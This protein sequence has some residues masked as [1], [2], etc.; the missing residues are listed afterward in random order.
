L[1]AN[2][3]QYLENAGSLKELAESGDFVTAMGK[4]GHFRIDVGSDG[5]GQFR[6][7]VNACV[8]F[9]TM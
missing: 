9:Q 5:G 1:L 6:V 7:L 3:R 2:K 4:N 8:L